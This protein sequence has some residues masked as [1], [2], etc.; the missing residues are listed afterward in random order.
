[1]T[2][3]TNLCAGVFRGGCRREGGWVWS[4]NERNG[5]AP[6]ELHPRGGWRIWVCNKAL[7]VS[8][9][10][11]SSIYTSTNVALLSLVDTYTYTGI[12]VLKLYAC[13]H[14][15]Y[16][17]VV[18]MVARKACSIYVWCMGQVAL[19]SI[20]VHSCLTYIFVTRV[21]TKFQLFFHASFMVNLLK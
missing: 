13:V 3:S 7:T 11:I 17:H 5:E 18:S 16:V 9:I 8:V 20:I 1:M 14:L 19:G 6:C 4:W 21:H 10:V 12:L 2:P 15:L